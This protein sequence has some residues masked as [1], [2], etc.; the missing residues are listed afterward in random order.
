MKKKYDYFAVLAG[1]RTGSNFLERNLNAVPDVKSYGEL[2]NPHFVGKA[3]DKTLFGI[4]LEARES[5]PAALL[6]CIQE[7]TEG[8]PGF[9]LFHDHDVRIRDVVLAN[10]RCAKII[11]TRNPLESFVSFRHAV[12]SDQWMMT[13]ARNKVDVPPIEFKAD[14]FVEFARKQADYQMLIRQRLAALGQ[15]ALHVA[16]EDLPE[17][18]TL[19]GILS[20]LGSA[21]RLERPDRSIKRQNAVELTARVSNP[22]AMQEALTQIDPFQ[23]DPNASAR[24]DRGAAVRSYVAARGTGVLYLPAHDLFAP[25]I[26][27]WFRALDDTQEPLTGM[28]QR[29]LRD[30]RRAHPGARC[31]SVLVHPVR[32]AWEV[33]ETRILPLEDQPLGAYREAL[34]KHYGIKLPKK[35]PDPELPEKALRQAFLGFC[36]FLKANLSEQTGL[37]IQKDWLG[38][39]TRLH[40]TS[41]VALPDVILREDAAAQGLS[42]LAAGMGVDLP[43]LELP[44]PPELLETVYDPMVEKA[45]RQAFARD[46]A[47]FG[48][49]N[50]TP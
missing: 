3:K 21:H 48:F 46:Y 39:H 27:A 42:L 1:M 16:Y 24:L 34:E 49:D 30:W 45:V 41:A 17:L 9:R 28:S 31:F 18:E 25:Q 15:T 22:D 11:L 10:P 2:F 8:L 7:K 33:F 12:E 44:K 4:T 14:A 40:G 26:N 23:L 47:V 20:F 37:G 13:D 32:R 19:N 29:D 43:P 6:K 50:W 5:D 35:W 38:Q 36:K